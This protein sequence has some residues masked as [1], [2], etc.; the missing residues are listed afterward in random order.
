VTQQIDF[1]PDE[2]NPCAELS[3][4]VQHSVHG[5]CISIL[6]YAMYYDSAAFQ[7]REIKIVLHCKVLDYGEG[8]SF[9]PLGSL[10]KNCASKPGG[11]GKLYEGNG[12]DPRKTN[13]TVRSRLQ[14][15][16]PLYLTASFQGAHVHIN[17]N[18]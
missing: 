17:D 16:A 12:V 10:Q 8:L 6:V 3:Q 15:T 5:G 9:Q 13:V 14:V 4:G 11:A 18:L 7:I 1:L 2:R